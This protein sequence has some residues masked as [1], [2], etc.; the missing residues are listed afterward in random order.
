MLNDSEYLAR[1]IRAAM[2]SVGMKSTALAEKCAVSKQA[3][4]GWLTT[5]RISKKS[6][7]MV[8][9]ITGKPIEF[10]IQNSDA[11]YESELSS[12]ATLCAKALDE[13]PVLIR[14]QLRIS[15]EEIAKY[16]SATNGFSKDLEGR[17]DSMERT[18]RK[19]A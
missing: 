18:K 19:R 2:D 12:D 17:T 13:L 7:L 14:R 1:Q 4:N 5:G 11:G 3:V 8:C 9:A 16:V 10:F 15:I 6:L